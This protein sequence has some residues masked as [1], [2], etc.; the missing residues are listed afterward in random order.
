MK[1]FQSISNYL[2][3]CIII[4]LFKTWNGRMGIPSGIICRQLCYNSKGKY[5]IQGRKKEQLL[6]KI[7]LPWMWFF[8]IVPK[9]GTLAGIFMGVVSSLEASSWDVRKKKRA[10]SGWY[11]HAQA[12][13][14]MLRRPSVWR[15]RKK[16]YGKE[17]FY[18]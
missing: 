13:P 11:F 5:H 10:E 4:I 14:G 15:P 2:M 18:Q 12:F 3:F 16:R 6:Q 9:R 7:K 8:P 17:Q 1:T